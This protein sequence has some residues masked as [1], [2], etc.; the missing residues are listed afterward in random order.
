VVALELVYQN[1]IRRS[2]NGANFNVEIDRLPT[3]SENYYQETRKAVQLVESKKQGQLYLMY[4]GGVDSEYALSAFIDQKINIKPVVV[5]LNPSYNSHDIDHAFKFCTKHNLEP[6]VVDIDY[7]NF[8][9]S[10]KMLELALLT[11][12]SIPHYTTTAFA[13]SKL[14]GTVICGDGEPHLALDQKTGKWNICIYEFEYALTN[15]YE[16]NKINGV[17]HFNRYTPQMFKTFLEDPRMN[18][19]SNNLVNGK[20]GSHSSKWLI[21]NRHSNFNLEQRPKYHGLEQIENS[22]IKQHESF[23][24]LEKIGKQWDGVWK[25]EYSQL[26]K[27]IC[28]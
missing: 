3:T 6:V 17:V 16:K 2:G 10:G 8:V 14:D 26:V 21:Y 22:P 19:L 13:I 20:L 1:Y 4:S 28:T 15:F 18:D 11:E 25:K 5:K 7:E 24:E 27:E 12:S 9:Y 23:F